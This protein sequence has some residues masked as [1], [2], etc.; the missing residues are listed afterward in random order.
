MT[1]SQLIEKGSIWVLPNEKSGKNKGV[2]TKLLMLRSGFSSPKAERQLLWMTTVIDITATQNY[3]FTADMLEVG[4]V[5]RW[6]MSY[7]DTLGNTATSSIFS[8]R[9]QDTAAP[10]VIEDPAQSTNVPEYNETVVISIRVEEDPDAEGLDTVWLNYT[11][12]DW[13]TFKIINI[14]STQNYTFSADML[15]YGQVYQWIIGFNDTA[16]NTGYTIDFSFTVVNSAH[17]DYFRHLSYL[18]RQYRVKFSEDV[19]MWRV[20]LV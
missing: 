13:N 19:P 1:I 2:E 18:A 8:F 7:N 20:V 17:R 3:T 4:Q 12:T 16:G 15:F 11:T 6:F 10:D 14:T 5:Y 9:I